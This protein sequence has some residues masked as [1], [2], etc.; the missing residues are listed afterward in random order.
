[1]DLVK[2]AK[3]DPRF[4]RIDSKKTKVKIDSRFKGVLNDTAFRRISNK[5]QYGRK[6]KEEEKLE[7]IYDIPDSEIENIENEQWDSES[8]DDISYQVDHGLIIE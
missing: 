4:N 6:V 7:E 5:D 8:G 3:Q 1:M 2:K